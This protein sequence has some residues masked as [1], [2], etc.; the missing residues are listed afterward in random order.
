MTQSILLR[1]PPRELNPNVRA[2]RSRKMKKTREYRQE[3]GWEAKAQGIRRMV[4]NSLM[5]TI[6]FCPPNKLWDDDNMEATFK[7]GRDGL[8]DVIGV[9]D[10][11]WLVRRVV[12]SPI[13][14][15][16]ILVRIDPSE[17]SIEE[18]RAASNV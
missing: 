12:G 16:S 3:C 5:V 7:A 2:K 11:R 14:N 1:W 8:A 18:L 13:R 6:E 15:G 10:N 9:D 4:A 17:L